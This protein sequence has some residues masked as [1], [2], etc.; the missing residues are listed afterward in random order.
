MG[1]DRVSRTARIRASSHA[2]AVG[3]SWRVTSCIDIEID[4]FGTV[5]YRQANV[6]IGRM[7]EIH[8]HWSGS[9]AEGLGVGGELAE[10]E[11]QGAELETGGSSLKHSYT[12]E[13]GHYPM[14][15]R[16]G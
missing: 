13:F 7:T 10:L 5:K 4:D 14:H 8:E 1:E 11:H 2:A 3:E 16:R 6:Q 12:D 15:G 9:F